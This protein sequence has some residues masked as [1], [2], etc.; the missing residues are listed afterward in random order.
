M[1]ERCSNV[2]GSGF[3]VLR[4]ATRRDHAELERCLESV[5]YMRELTGWDQASEDEA[6]DELNHLE[7]PPGGVPER[8]RIYLV[9]S[10]DRCLGYTKFYE[11][12]PV[13]TT[14]FLGCLAIKTE[15]Q[16]QGWGALVLGVVEAELG[17]KG[18]RTIR[19]N[20][21]TRNVPAMKFW[22][23][24]GFSRIVGH[25]LAAPGFLDVNLE[26]PIGS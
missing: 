25:S 21:G 9:W 18:Y 11:G 20:V 6:S 7:L 14:A 22:M 24:R 3:L 17:A 2:L 26:K 13:D 19:I 12:W 23:E 5:D 4:E 15:Y 1:L 8:D 10:D 16:R